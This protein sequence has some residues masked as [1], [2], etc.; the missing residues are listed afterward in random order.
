LNK[1]PFKSF[2]P[3]KIR[4]NPQ[5]QEPREFLRQR[6]PNPFFLNFS[7]LRLKSSPAESATATHPRSVE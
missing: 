5:K 2:Q 1:L 6:V 3:Q 7:F 4:Q